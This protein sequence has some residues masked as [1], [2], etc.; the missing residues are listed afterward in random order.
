M[1]AKTDEAVNRFWY[2]PDSVFGVGDAVY[3]GPD[4]NTARLI[5]DCNAI[6]DLNLWDG[7]GFLMA[8]HIV[9]VHNEWLRR[10]QADEQAQK[11]GKTE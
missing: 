7:D 3:D 5:C 10:K 4:P 9:L 11:E 6:H 1:Y 8:L 2:V